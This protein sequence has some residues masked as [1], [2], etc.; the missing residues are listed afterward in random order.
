MEEIGSIIVNKP[1]KNGKSLYPIVE[2]KNVQVKFFG[3]RAAYLFWEQY[4]NNGKQ[5]LYK[6]SQEIRVME[7]INEEWKILNL[8]TFWDYENMVPFEK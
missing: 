8:S 6:K 5:S 4:Q 1:V 3:E 7:K 2:R